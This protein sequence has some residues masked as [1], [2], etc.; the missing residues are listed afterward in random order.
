ME[1]INLCGDLYNMTK[2]GICAGALKRDEFAVAV[3]VAAIC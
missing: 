1:H 2:N 3:A